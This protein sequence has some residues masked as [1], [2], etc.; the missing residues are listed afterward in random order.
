[1]RGFLQKDIGSEQALEQQARAV[2]DSTKLRQYMEWIADDP[3]NAGS[4]R[5]K[6]V[7][8]HLVMRLKSWGLDAQIEEFEALMPYPTVRQ[9][10]V[11]GP[12]RYVAKLKEPVIAVDPDS[13]D[14]HQLPTYNAYSATGD[15][16]GEVVCE[17]RCTGR[18]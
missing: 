15:V 13:S 8:E 6:A 16:T 10:E 2:P 14:A 9:V 4:A 17:F 11:L 5:S 18:L 7:A 12:K 3:H 1:M